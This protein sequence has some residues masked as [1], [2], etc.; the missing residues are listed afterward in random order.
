MES[1][2]VYVILAITGVFAVIIAIL[3]GPSLF[4]SYENWKIKRGLKR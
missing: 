3:L 2:G 1:A 4:S